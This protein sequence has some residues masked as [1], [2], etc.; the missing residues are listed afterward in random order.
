MRNGRE[1]LSKKTFGEANRDRIDKCAVNNKGIECT[2]REIVR[3]VATLKKLGWGGGGGGEGD[4]WRR[5]KK[6][7]EEEEN[8]IT[9]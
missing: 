6:N 8:S 3:S 7:K 2:Q 1:E 4:R 5:K 9:L